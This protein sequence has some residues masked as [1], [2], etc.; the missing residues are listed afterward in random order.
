V[1]ATEGLRLIDKKCALLPSTTSNS[2]FGYIWSD[3][4]QG[5][6]TPHL[7]DQIWLVTGQSTPLLSSL[8]TLRLKQ[9]DRLAASAS[10]A[11]PKGALQ[12]LILNHD[13][14]PTIPKLGFVSLESD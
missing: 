5:S 11:A 1:I 2:E 4:D 10:L 8:L 13:H 6:F 12:P 3:P 7:A 9:H 14:Q